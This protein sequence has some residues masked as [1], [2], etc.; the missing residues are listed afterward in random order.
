[1]KPILSIWLL[2][3]LLAPFTGAY[4]W[5]H[6]QKAQV[7]HQVKQQLLH[8]LPKE[9]LTLLIFTKQEAHTQLHWEDKNEFEYQ[10]QMYDVVNTEIHGNT[11]WYWCW[12]DRKETHIQQQL[13]Q[14][15]AK[16]TDQHIPYKETQKQLLHFLSELYYPTPFVWQ[17]LVI[18]Q[19]VLSLFD[20]PQLYISCTFSPAS[21]PPQ[22]VV[23]I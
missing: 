1:M 14:L 15:I 19:D 20:Y 17:A 23:S 18:Q 12:N 7:R 4:V 2:L 22:A 3:C 13:A 5:L 6:Y 16:A 10:H 9:S 21:P 8:S 11:T